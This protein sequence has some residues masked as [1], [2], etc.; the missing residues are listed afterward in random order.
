MAAE[1]KWENKEIKDGIM[2][3][4][5]S[6]WKFFHD[7]VVDELLEFSHCIWRGQRD[8]SWNLISSLDR[9]LTE[10]KDS[11]KVYLISSHL[12]E[13]KRVI[14]GRRGVN[15][16]PIIEENEW[17]ALGQHHALATPLLDWTHSP[18]V[19]LY[20]AFEKDTKP[21]TNMRTVWA[22]IEPEEANS[23][24]KKHEQVSGVQQTLDFVVPSQSENPRLLSQA[25]LFTRGPIGESVE[26]WV[27][28][29]YKDKSSDVPLLKINIPNDGRQECLKTL[30]RMNINHATLFPDLY[31]AGYYCNRLINIGA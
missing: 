9:L 30:N 18:F 20:F 31:G 22:L 15:P 14:R 4:N 2:E 12:K 28:R 1:S 25:G 17:W 19:A 6:S 13:F 16:A 24:I 23:R 27:E 3:V 21:K 5:L 11:E 26:S 7:Y 29:E 10:K 8:S